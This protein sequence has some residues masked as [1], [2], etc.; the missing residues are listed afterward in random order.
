M[1]GISHTHLG[2]VHS[3]QNTLTHGF[4]SGTTLFAQ[5]LQQ[6]FGLR[7]NAIQFHHG[8]FGGAS[9]VLD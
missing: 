2:L 7:D 3:A 9:A 5:R 4:S 6:L 1:T 8:G